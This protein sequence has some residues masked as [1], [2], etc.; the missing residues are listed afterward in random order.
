MTTTERPECTRLAAEEAE[1]VWT[2]GQLGLCGSGENACAPYCCRAQDAF[3]EELVEIMDDIANEVQAARVQESVT[4]D[5]VAEGVDP[6]VA[7]ALSACLQVLKA[8]GTLISM[9]ADGWVPGWA[10][11]LAKSLGMDVSILLEAEEITNG[12]RQKDYGD[13][14]TNHERIAA[15]WSAWMKFDKDQR[16]GLSPNMLPE[17][18]AALMILMKIA[19]LQASATRDSLVDIA[20]YANVLDKMAHQRAARLA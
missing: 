19:R 17:D 4:V 9:D 12:Q 5:Y 11:K 8:G 14:L 15:L 13:A 6:K 1:K 10:P 18:V 2:A 20:G 3:D 7:Q 16:F